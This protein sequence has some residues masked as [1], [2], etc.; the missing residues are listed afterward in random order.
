MNR[1]FSS[2]SAIGIDLHPLKTSKKLIIGG[3]QIPFAKGLDGHSDGD[4]L[5]HA[6]IDS[7]LGV[8]ALG[9]IGTF[10]PDSNPN[11]HKKYSIDLLSETVKMVNHKGWYLTFLD[12]T[13][14]A[15]SPKMSDH[16]K[17]IK[18][19]ISSVIKINYDEI[20]IKATSTNGLGFIGKQEG[21]AAIAIATAEKNLND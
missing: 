14:I 15:E 20:S 13:I 8:A 9:D 11:Y 3:V 19:T 16:I 5:T 10:F 1:N 7:I 21:I 17:K 12:A 2:R 6:I 18:T 4:V